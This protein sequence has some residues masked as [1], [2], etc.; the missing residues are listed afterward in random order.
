[1]SEKSSRPSEDFDDFEPSY[2][3]DLDPDIDIVVGEP[4][5]DVG[6]AAQGQSAWKRLEERNEARWLEE[7]LSDWDDWG[8]GDDPRP[9]R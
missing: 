1:M 2:D 8:D 9:A 7:Q 5:L 4:D 6:N 3:L